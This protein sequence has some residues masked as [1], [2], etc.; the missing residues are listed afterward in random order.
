MRKESYITLLDD[1]R[2]LNFKLTQMSAMQQTRWASKA[3]IL[4]SATGVVKSLTQFEVDKLQKQFEAEGLNMVLDLI[5][6]LDYEKVEPLFNELLTCAA[7]I[8][9][10]NNRN[11]VTAITTNNIDSIVTDFKNVYKLAIEAFKVNFTVS[12]AGNSSP[13]RKQADI[14]IPK[15]M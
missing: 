8:P 9:D 11:F 5:G 4:L 3:V 10:V 13:T 15:S 2:E 6:K 1:G 7:Y 14:V 12:A